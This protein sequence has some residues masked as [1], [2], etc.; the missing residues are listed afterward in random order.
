MRTY[1]QLHDLSASVCTVPGLPD[2]ACSRAAEKTLPGSDQ[3]KGKQTSLR[4]WRSDA[5]VLLCL[6]TSNLRRA[7]RGARLDGAR[8][9]AWQALL[10]GSM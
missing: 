3:E 7:A 2:A 4:A 6:G 10:L 9:E 8:A 5:I 1:D